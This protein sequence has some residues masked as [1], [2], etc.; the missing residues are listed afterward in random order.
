MSPDKKKKK[1]QNLD[2]NKP[3]GSRRKKRKKQTAGEAMRRRW[4]SPSR[5]LPGEREEA[6]EEVEEWGVEEVEG[7]GDR[8]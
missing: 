6:G 8:E 7:R 4:R 5:V 1:D 2:V 3:A